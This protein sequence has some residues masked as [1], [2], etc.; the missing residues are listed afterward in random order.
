MALVHIGDAT[1][2]TLP[3]SQLP[4]PPIPPGMLPAGMQVPQ[5]PGQLPQLPAVPQQ[6]P[7][8]PQQLPTS[9][10]ALAAINAMSDADYH[11]AC[12]PCLQSDREVARVKN[13]QLVAGAV[14][15]ALGAVLVKYVLPRVR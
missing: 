14:G 13:T 4:A 8:V 11:T 7:T 15:V 10:T 2:G 9:P 1:S 3:A 5:L 6:T 12:D